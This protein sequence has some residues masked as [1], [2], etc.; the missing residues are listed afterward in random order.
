MKYSILALT[1]ASVSQAHKLSAY[2]QQKHAVDFLDESGESVTFESML[3]NEKSKPI[4]LSN[5]QIK[6][7]D[8]GD[9]AAEAAPADA[10]AAEAAQ[11]EA[12]AAAQVA[13]PAAIDDST[14]EGA[15]LKFAQMQ[16]QMEANVQAADARKAQQ[17]AAT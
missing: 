17:D 13:A 12:Q 5:L 6:S 14:P 8:D 15:R 2:S 7:E 11:Q 10:Q 3:A 4:E 1:F 16:A 9:A